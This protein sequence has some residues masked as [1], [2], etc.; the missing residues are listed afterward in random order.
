MQLCKFEVRLGQA[1]LNHIAD[2]DDSDQRPILHDRQMADALIG[3]DLH[4]FDDLVTGAQVWT[5]HVINSCALRQVKLARSFL[6][7]RSEATS[8]YS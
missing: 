4:E 8:S 7:L 2:T 3:H 5:S 6:H 1:L